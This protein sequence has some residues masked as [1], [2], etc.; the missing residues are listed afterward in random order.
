MIF[1]RCPI[2]CITASTLFKVGTAA[3]ERGHQDSSW[4]MAAT[5]MLLVGGGHPHPGGES[6]PPPRMRGHFTPVLLFSIFHHH[7]THGSLHLICC[8]AARLHLCL[9]R[10]FLYSRDL[11]LGLQVLMRSPCQSSALGMSTRGR[12]VLGNGGR[13]CPCQPGLEALGRLIYPM[14]GSLSSQN[15]NHASCIISIL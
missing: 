15:S 7:M 11:G 6:P 9:L 8:S 10:P 5:N 14:P 12:A 1:L 2:D 13:H 3:A 4:G